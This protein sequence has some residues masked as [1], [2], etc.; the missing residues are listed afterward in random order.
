MLDNALIPHDAIQAL[1][2]GREQPT[3]LE[4]VQPLFSLKEASQILG[5]GT[6][7]VSGLLRTKRL[8]GVVRR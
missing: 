6:E 5:M 4:R 1:A 7:E 8:F 3:R 2:D